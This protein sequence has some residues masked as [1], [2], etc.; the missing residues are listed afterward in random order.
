MGWLNRRPTRPSPTAVEGRRNEPRRD[1]TYYPQ[2]SVRL[3]VEEGLKPVPLPPQFTA[4]W[5]EGK[6]FDHAWSH[7]W[8][9]Q[10]L[11]DEVLSIMA[12]P[13][14]NIGHTQP[15][16]LVVAMPRGIHH[17]VGERANIVAPPSGS[18]GSKVAVDPN[19]IF[20]DPR[21]SKLI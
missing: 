11:S 4:A 19:M 20:Y 8:L 6:T 17:A 9:Y 12:W 2:E 14:T 15:G 1:R 18:Y 10:S 16:S 21:Y 3:P 5:P 7:R 13:F